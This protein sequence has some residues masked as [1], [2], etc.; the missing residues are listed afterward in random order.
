MLSRVAD[1]IYWMGRYL[2]RAENT[3]RFLD[4]NWNLAL[5]LPHSK[6]EPWEALVSVTGDRSVFTERYTDATKEN[7]IQFLGFDAD[8][9]NSM[10]WVWKIGV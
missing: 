5:D 3:A 1:A 2:E 9:P 4:V 7:I 8:Y 6:L 10:L